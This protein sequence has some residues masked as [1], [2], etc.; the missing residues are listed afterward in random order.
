M[1]LSRLWYIVCALI[2]RG[3]AALLFSDATLYT[4]ARNRAMREAL[5]A[6]SSAVHWYLKDDSRNRAA[7]LIQIALNADVQTGLAKATSESKPS[8]EV[9]EKMKA[10]LR[11][12]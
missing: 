4:R 12:L 7:A 6:D 10:A 9:R 8:R 1:R 5:A 2:I 3:L 11:K